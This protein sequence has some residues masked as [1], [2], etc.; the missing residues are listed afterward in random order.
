[1]SKIL[2]FAVLVFSINIF[3]QGIFIPNEI[4]KAVEKQ[5]R[6]LEGI[7]GEKY[8]TNH[9][10]YKIEAEINFSNST[11]IGTEKIVYHNES[12]DT[13]KRLVIRLLNDIQKPGATRDYFWGNANFLDETLIKSVVINNHK[14]D[15]SDTS[16][17]INRGSTNLSVNLKNYILPKTKNEIE[18][19]WEMVVPSE[20]K[21]RMGDF[22]DGEMFVAYWYPQVAVYDDVFGWDNIDYQGNVEFYNDINNFDVKLKLPKNFVMWSTGILQNPTELFSDKILKKYENAKNS[23]E[24]VRIITSEDRKEGNITKDSENLIWHVIAEKVPDFSFAISDNFLWDGRNLKNNNPKNPNVFVQAVYREGSVFWE[25]AAEI[26]AKSIKYMSEI[27]PGFPFPYPSMI[28]VTNG[29]SDGGMETPMMANDGAPKEY[30]SF[31]GLLFHEISHT[32]FPFFMGTNERRFSWMDEGWAT[33]FPKE[34]VEEYQKDA[35]SKYWGRMVK[36]FEHESG[37][38]MDIPLVTPSFS[39]K[40]GYPR[41]NFYTRP[42]M[43]YMELQHL[44]GKELFHKAILDYMN[45]WQGKHPIPTDFFASFEKTFGQDLSW[46]WKPWFYEFGTTDLSIDKV[47][48][49]EN[50]IF[51]AIKKDGNLPT[52]IVITITYKNGKV[53]TKEFSSLEWKDK[54]LSIYKFEKL[55]EVEKVELGSSEIPDVNRNNN[56]IEY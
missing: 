14:I 20:R 6:T 38:S 46:F 16:K 29:D 50:E 55:G 17:E 45:T 2:T 7:P 30:S 12:L 52:R 8:W 47:K 54:N 43:A 1:M 44:F 22:S 15:V 32:Y 21:I 40:G 23:E 9:A 51:V 3:A 24:V 56:I 5:T 4:K 36:G 48:I 49:E 31:V 19:T 28:S 13:L 41:M 10:D 37:N 27:M 11:I 26:S 53:Q 25:D 34:I 39:V 33:L 42:A 18:I 35:K